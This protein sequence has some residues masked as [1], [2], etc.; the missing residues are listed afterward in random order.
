MYFEILFL[1]LITYFMHQILM[2]FAKFV[3]LIDNPNERSI[4][5]SP[6]IRGF[7]IVIFVSI[8]ITLLV[9][10]PI[11]FIQNTNLLSAVL[12]IGILGLIDDVKGTPPL[13]KILTLIVVY[14]FLYAD[15]FLI[16]YLGV[17][18]G[19]SIDLNLYLAIIFSTAAIVAFTNAFNIIDGL[20]GLSGLI[21][22]IIFFTFLF[23]GLENNDKLLTTI[24]IFFITTL[25][26]FLIY[27]WNPAKVFL[28]DSGS[29]MIGFVISILGIRSLNYIE[30]ISILF[31]ASV[32]IIDA[33]FVYSRRILEGKPPFMPDKLHCHHILLAYFKHN[34]KKT[35]LIIASFQFISSLVGVCYFANLNDSF[36]AL[37][38]FLFLFFAVFKIL[39]R[40][41]VNLNQE[42]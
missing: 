23:L 29:L 33:L 38:F 15:G 14:L 1:L 37:L 28:G 4:H 39:I 7:G 6:T 26:V 32:P 41:R 35:V 34:V 22:M 16:S 24:P 13:I 12:L 42:A 2:K 11:M 10:E 21:A 19:I 25:F 18:L 20:D 40:I 30:P 9:F 8:G 5:I 36:F 27:N 3:N 31:I 17:Y